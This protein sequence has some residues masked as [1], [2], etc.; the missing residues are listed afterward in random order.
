[1]PNPL[2]RKTAPGGVR[3]DIADAKQQAIDEANQQA[4]DIDHRFFG[5]GNHGAS[6]STPA[7]LDSIV[8]GNHDINF[9]DAPVGGWSSLSLWPDGRYQFSGHLHDSGFPSY[10]YGVVWLLAGSAGTAFVFKHQGHVHGDLP[11]SRD[12]DW[13]DSDTNQAIADAWNELSAAYRWKLSAE[14]D[15]DLGELVDATA[16]AVG[17]VAKV[18]EIASA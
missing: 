10:D 6:P 7:R 12:D 16:K 3:K 14:V 15:A 13:S 18:V 17:N 9:E 4:I 2:T 11:G 8:L 1:M 5:G